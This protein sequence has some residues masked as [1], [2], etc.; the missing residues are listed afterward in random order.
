MFIICVTCQRKSW[1]LLSTRILFSEISRR[2]EPKICFWFSLTPFTNHEHRLFYQ[3]FN[4]NEVSPKA[5]NWYE[6]NGSIRAPWG[7][8]LFHASCHV[9]TTWKLQHLSLVTLSPSEALLC[10]I[11]THTGDEKLQ[12]PEQTCKRFNLIELIDLNRFIFFRKWIQ[13]I[14]FVFASEMMGDWVNSF[15]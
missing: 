8:T 1:T 3:I 7:K 12:K 9:V 11:C 13:L 4:F 5:D 14:Q 15:S 2:F 6:T 10:A